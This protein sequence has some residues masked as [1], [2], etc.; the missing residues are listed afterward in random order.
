MEE[1]SNYLDEVENLI[2]VKRIGVIEDLVKVAKFLLKD[3]TNFVNGIIINSDGG[4]RNLES[5]TIIQR[6]NHKDK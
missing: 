6:Q 4:L 5:S 3:S 1:N 2:P